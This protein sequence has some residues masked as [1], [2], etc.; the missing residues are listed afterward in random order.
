M[1]YQG[2]KKGELDQAEMWEGKKLTV[3]ALSIV[4]NCLVRAVTSVVDGL[5][6]I[7]E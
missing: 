5:E 3:L 1:N 7:P 2:E 6:A 4:S